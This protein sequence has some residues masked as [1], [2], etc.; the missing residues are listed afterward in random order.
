MSVHRMFAAMAASLV[1]LCGC[2][3]DEGATG[4]GNSPT[5]DGSGT[6]SRLAP[7]DAAER[8]VSKVD[9]AYVEQVNTQIA[10]LEIT[11]EAMKAAAAKHPDDELLAKLVDRADKKIP[12]AKKK[13]EHI[14]K[15][16]RDEN[17][18]ELQAEIDALLATIADAV[19]KGVK[20]SAK[21]DQMPVREPR[22]PRERR[23][24]DQ[25]D[26]EVF[27]DDTGDGGE[28]DDGSGDLR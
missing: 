22:Q 27:E 15:V 9:P 8:A 21:L 26:D 7:D 5:G 25:M 11:T 16:A 19:D 23:N 14:Q 12:T 3:T 17:V 18:A 6:A 1:L 24:T 10:D 2:D 4:G 13:I 20:R 28:S